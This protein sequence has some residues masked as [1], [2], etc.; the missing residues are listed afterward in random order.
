MRL[1]FI[2]LLPAAIALASWAANFA[3]ARNRDLEVQYARE[4]LDYDFLDYG[5]DRR[6]FLDELST[7]ELVEELSERLERRGISP[8]KAL[9]KAG[10]KKPK[11]SNSKPFKCPYCGTDYAT[12][13]E[14]K[15][16]A[17]K[18]ALL[19]GCK[20]AGAVQHKS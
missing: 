3:E 14:A 8:S 2:T 13:Q 5:F 11:R 17:T 15:D 4:L 7:R 12:Q 6:E 18:P 10:L 16:C 9:E 20:V 19:G 1:S